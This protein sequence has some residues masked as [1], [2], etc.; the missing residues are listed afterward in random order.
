MQ[1]GNLTTPI[2]KV[3]LWT[4]RVLTGLAVAFFL[5]DAVGKFMKPAVVVET[6]MKLGYLESVITPLKQAVMKKD[7]ATFVPAYKTMLE[8]C[9]SC[10][11]SSGKPYLR[12]MIPAAPPQ[13]IISYDPHAKWP[14]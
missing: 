1:G 7:A 4:G 9:Y 2:S 12:P 8:A 10:H 14:Q 3:Q 13:T 11:K 5:F 6:T